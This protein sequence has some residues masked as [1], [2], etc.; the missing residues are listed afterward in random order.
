MSRHIDQ[1]KLSRSKSLN[2][3]ADKTSRKILYHNDMSEYATPQIPNPIC[4]ATSVFAFLFFF[5]SYIKTWLSTSCAVRGSI[6][7]TLSIKDEYTGIICSIC[8]FI[9][10]LLHVCL[11]FT[12]SVVK[13]SY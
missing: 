3:T 11:F 8:I 10:T 4:G 13:R 12:I 5:P 2:C 1:V 7:A 9:T 6:R